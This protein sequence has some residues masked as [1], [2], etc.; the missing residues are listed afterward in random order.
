VV[1]SSI[2]KDSLINFAIPHKVFEEAKPSNG[3]MKMLL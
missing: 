1:A 2:A 3:K